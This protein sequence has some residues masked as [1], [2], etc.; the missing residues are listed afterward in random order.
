MKNLIRQPADNHTCIAP[1]DLASGDPFM[2]GSRFMV[3]SN[4][5]KSG[6]TVVGVT[7]GEYSLRKATGETWAD[8]DKLYWDATAEKLTKTA[9][10]NAHVALASGAALSADTAGPVELRIAA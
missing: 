8:G 9:T 7:R 6:E 4:A 1:Y 10:G 5:A 3:A 2:V